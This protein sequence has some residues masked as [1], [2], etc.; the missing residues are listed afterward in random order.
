MAWRIPWAD[1]VPSITQVRCRDRREE[2]P[3]AA[4]PAE[5]R[6]RSG[7]SGSR[8]PRDRIVGA[9]RTVT[10]VSSELPFPPSY[11]S[12]PCAR[13]GRPIPTVED[14]LRGAG[15]PSLSGS[16]A[17]G[18]DRAESSGWGAPETVSAPEPDAE[19]HGA[20]LSPLTPRVPGA[21]GPDPACGRLDVQPLGRRPVR[22]GPLGRDRRSGAPCGRNHRRRTVGVADALGPGGN[23]LTNESGFVV[24]PRTAIVRC[25]ENGDRHVPDL[26]SA[27]PGVAVSR[28]RAEPERPGPGSTCASGRRSSCRPRS[29]RRRTRR[30]PRGVSRS[31]RRTRGGSGA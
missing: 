31:A 4:S 28:C 20:P 3:R 12:A 2:A 13:S 29:A 24:V 26:D 9:D 23:E 6:S 22:G 16:V 8:T 15:A 19:I 18:P 7:A 5:A 11:A 30:A 1:L 21:L 27:T 17:P 14:R 25:D 10:V